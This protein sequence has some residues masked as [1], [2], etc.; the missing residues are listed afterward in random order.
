[1]SLE[2]PVLLDDSEEPL[3]EKGPNYAV[4]GAQ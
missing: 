1:V 4:R 3:S 2:V